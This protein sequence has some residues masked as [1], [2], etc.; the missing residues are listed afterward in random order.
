MSNT[1]ALQWDSCSLGLLQPPWVCGIPR[2]WV[3]GHWAAHLEYSSSQLTC[4]VVLTYR[5]GS[6]RRL[7]RVRGP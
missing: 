3:W 6:P 5:L 4:A 2:V 1:A 7:G